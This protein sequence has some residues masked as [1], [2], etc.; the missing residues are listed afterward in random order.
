[1]REPLIWP[2]GALTAGILVSRFTG[3]QA[4]EVWPGFAALLVV[5][6]VAARWGTRRTLAAGLLL[7]VVAAGALCE[8]YHRRLPPPDLFLDSREPVLVRG[9]VVE[10]PVLSE[11]RQQFTLE[12]APGARVRVSLY[13]RAGEAPPLLAYGQTVELE[14]RVRRPRN[15]QNPGSF[16]YA[17]WLARRNVWWLAAARRGVRPRLLPKPCGSPILSAV[18]R[19]RARAA[20]R[21]DQLYAGNAYT[22]GMMRALLLG[23]ASRLE[24]VWTDDFRR[25]GTYHA[26]VISGLHV[27]VLATCFLFLLRLVR[28]GPGGSLAATT[29]AAW[30]YALL[31]GGT[32]P[33]ARAAA[34]L[35][36]YLV[37]RFFYRQGRI[38]NLLALVAIVFLIH[39]PDQLFDASFQLSFLAVALIGG[40]AVPWLERTS[41]PYRNGVEGLTETDRDLHL[42]GKVAQFRVELRLL[43]ETLRW[44]LRVPQA[45]SLPLIGWLL[46]M[47]FYL[48]EL[49]VV[50]AIVQVGMML[51][52]VVF[53]HRASVSGLS[54]NVIA[55]P[56][57]SALIPAGFLAILT[58][59]SLPAVAAG[60]LLE[61][62]R[63]VVEWHARLEPNWRIP[64]PPPWLAC[65]FAFALLMVAATVRAG[66]LARAGAIALLVVLLGLLLWH[67]FA[68]RLEKGSLELTA[69]DVGQG[70]SLFVA[71]PDG[72]TM[73]VDTGGVPAFGGARRPRLDMGEDVVSPYLWSRSIRRLDALV[74]T[75]A[76]ED[77]IG[78][79]ESIVANF[80]PREIWTA[81][82]MP[83]ISRRALRETAVRAGVGIVSLGAGERFTFGRAGVEV[84]A[85][86]AGYVPATTP[87]N[88]DSLVLR[89]VWGAHSF[90]LTGD[91]ER[92]VETALLKAG[93]ATK[94]DVLKV[95]HHGSRSSTTAPWLDS[96]RPAFAVISSGFENSFRHPH[97][98]V[99][100]RLGERH[101]AV[102][103][104]DRWGLVSVIS[105]GRRLRV[106]A[107]RWPVAGSG[108]TAPRPAFE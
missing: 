82:A 94:T 64:A 52:M 31:A 6:A 42:A 87:G 102:L 58:G 103:R 108:T 100:A 104:T 35:T 2:L 12:V 26:L 97:P 62:S 67:P 90:L 63:I 73:L 19:V 16:D 79:L 45:V 27:T 10:P 59:W 56:L 98:E 91:S 43:A 37:A 96:L 28:L 75:H 105:D 18:Y 15:F 40:L 68:P 3:L 76:H 36:L 61:A 39:D 99:V 33:V 74:V 44:W 41:T 69:I 65:G 11:D 71:L 48:Y 24:Q 51:P 14:A 9:C 88:N 34:G 77:H 54:A 95:A 89:L 46:R 107:H 101:A 106:E 93:L 7:V 60:W 53:F 50:S 32:A 38:V 4:A 22:T 70:E 72:K 66:R 5:S 92:P 21:L 23:D 20:E 49:A 57:M 25:T 80:R 55:G 17:G 81:A 8:I 83:R 86:P 47:A 30:L 29:A 84:L 78:G 1:M 13:L 85:P